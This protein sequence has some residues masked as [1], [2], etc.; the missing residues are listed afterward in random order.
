[1]NRRFVV[2]AL[3]SIAT[4]AFAETYDLDPSHSAATFTVQH[5]MFTKVHGEFG[6]VT[7][8]FTYD[9]K[10]PTKATVE[11]S[12][13]ATTVNTREPKRDTHLR[14]P[15]FFDVAKYARLTFKSTKVEK[16]A[17]GHL[18]LHGDLTIHGVTK[19]VVF[20]VT[21]PSPEIKDPWGA[22][23]IAASATATINRKDFGLNWNKALEAGGFLVGDEVTIELNLEG[24][25]K[26]PTA[27]K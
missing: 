19:N 17:K 12:V 22:T 1:M 3:L 16:G 14:S 18:K 23:K 21:G 25:K 26:A 7:G 11:A 15:D 24:S 10:E 4:P 9:P 5:L 20:D 6:G 2:A 13:D 27:A 8:S